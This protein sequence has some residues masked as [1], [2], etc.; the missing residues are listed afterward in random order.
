MIVGWLNFYTNRGRPAAAG[1]IVL[2]RQQILKESPK[3]ISFPRQRKRERDIDKTLSHSLI[4][5][6]V[7]HPPLVGGGGGGIQKYSKQPL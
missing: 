4:L 5:A 1:A 3:R 2:K 6:F 7:P